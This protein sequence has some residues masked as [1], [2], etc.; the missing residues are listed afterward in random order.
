MAKQPVVYPVSADLSAIL[1]ATVDMDA[2]WAE[3]LG[4]PTWPMPVLPVDP[5]AEAVVSELARRMKER[6][7]QLRCNGYVPRGQR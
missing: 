7:G 4:L 5:K 6:M 2:A 1:G 3:P